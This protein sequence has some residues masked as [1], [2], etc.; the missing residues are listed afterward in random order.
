MK[1]FVKSRKENLILLADAYKYS[2][3][4]LYYPGTTK[5][6]SYLESRG[7]KYDEVVFFGLQYYLKEYLEGAVFTKEDIDEAE[8][9]MTQV[10]GR[11]DVFDRSI[12]DY[13]LETHGGRLPICIKAVPEGMAIPTHQLLMTIENTDPKCFWLTNFLETLIMQIWYPITVATVSREIKKLVV[14]Y[15]DE[16]ATPGSES[17]I[18]FILNDFGCR[19]VSSMESA[20]IGA[21]AHLINF[22]GSDTII[23][24][25]F[26]QRYYYAQ[27]IFGMSI[28]ATEHS[29]CTLLGEQK[30]KEIF[31]HVLETFPTGIVACV[32]DSFNIFRACAQY[33]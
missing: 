2:H 7:G 15:F 1:P 18:D 21:S 32:S 20:G 12:F 8:E 10:F 29:I 13:I 19:G 23:G 11:S 6:Y 28:P 22:N 14:K 17:G 31:R 24:S 25:V 5:I 30:E 4:K 3:H 16:T 9:V 27:K 26:A 33:W